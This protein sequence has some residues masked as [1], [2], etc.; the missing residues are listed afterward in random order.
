[1]NFLNQIPTDR[2]DQNKVIT[3][4]IDSI[5][6]GEIDPLKALAKLKHLE[7][8]IDAIKQDPQV[9]ELISTEL[10]KYSKGE[11]ATAYGFEVAMSSKRTYDFK[12]CG[13]PQF[14][15]L[16]NDL[17]LRKKFLQNLTNSIVDVEN[18]G[19][20]IKMPLVK[21][22]TY[23]TLKKVGESIDNNSDFQI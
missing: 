21:H 8:I 16:E 13:D 9:T 15:K 17:K 23:F 2:F 11:K 20:E 14:E 1:M 5:L 12:N 7:N 4:S 18:G 19:V 6:N 10:G 22:S 3:E